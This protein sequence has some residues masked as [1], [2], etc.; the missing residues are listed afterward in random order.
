MELA[1]ALFI[2][3]L[4]HPTGGL[5]KSTINLIHDSGAHGSVVVKALCYR[6]EGHRFDTR[7]GDF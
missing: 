2:V 4:Y 6:P 7:R 5:R 3:Q 1:T